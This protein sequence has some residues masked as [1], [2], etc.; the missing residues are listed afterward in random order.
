MESRTTFLSKLR[1]ALCGRQRRQNRSTQQRNFPQRHESGQTNKR[2]RIDFRKFVAFPFSPMSAKRKPGRPVKMTPLRVH[3]IFVAI[4]NGA[5]ITQACTAAGVHPST[6]CKW[7]IRAGR[8]SYPRPKLA[9]LWARGL[10]RRDRLFLW[11]LAYRL[12]TGYALT[13]ELLQKACGR[14]RY[15][16]DRLLDIQADYP[17][18]WARM[19]MKRAYRHAGVSDPQVAEDKLY[20]ARTV[21]LMCRHPRRAQIIGLPFYGI[22]YSRSLRARAADT[23]AREETSMDPISGA[24]GNTVATSQ[25]AGRDELSQPEDPHPMP[26]CVQQF[27][28]KPG[29]ELRENQ[30]QSVFEA[31]GLGS[32]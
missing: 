8:R 30:E 22:I 2:A 7:A 16:Y 13:P 10:T 31:W 9:T 23:H 26:E 11:F 21:N 25:D 5:N 24:D 17:Q 27:I 20:A 19:L 3:L 4:A 12:P 14:C 18:A 15:S 6:Y 32:W 1:L 28:S 29:W